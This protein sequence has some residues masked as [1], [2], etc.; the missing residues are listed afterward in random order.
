MPLAGAAHRLREDMNF[1]R[2]LAAVGLRHAGDAD[3]GVVLDVGER[4]LDDAAD[5]GIV[6]Q[7]DLVRGLAVAR[8]DR[9]QRPVDRLHRAAHANW[10]R[11][12]GKARGCGKQQGEAGYPEN[13]P[14]GLVHVVL[15]KSRRRRSARQN[16]QPSA[17]RAYSWCPGF[18][19]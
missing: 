13:A 15:P 1:H 17:T 3:E 4:R 14:C 12:L 19:P 18:S 16:E 7:L 6:G 2:L 11:L 8:L 9:Q 10:R 5:R